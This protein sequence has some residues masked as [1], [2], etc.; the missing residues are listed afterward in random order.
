MGPKPH[1]SFIFLVF[2]AIIFGANAQFNDISDIASIYDIGKEIFEL[3][4]DSWIKVDSMH[5][6]EEITPNSFLRGKFFQSQNL[7]LSKMADISRRTESLENSV[8]TS[9]NDIGRLVMEIPAQLR[10]EL[11]LD[12]LATAIRQVM[13]AETSMATYSQAMAS[14]A[15]NGVELEVATLEDFATSTVSHASH[16]IRSML[17]D[18]HSMVVPKHNNLG[19]GGIFRL[20]L[21]TMKDGG[22]GL[23]SIHQSPQQLIFN[24]YNLVT[25]T[26]IKG[27]AMMQFSWMLLKLYNKGN[28]TL[29]AELMRERVEARM[30]EKIQAARTAMGRASQELWV[31]DPSHHEENE[32]FVQLTNV[33]QGHIENEV[34]LN[35][36]GTCRESCGYYQYAR[37]HD[38]YKDQFCK[39]QPKCNGRIFDCRFIDSDASVC[40]SKGGSTHRKYDWIEY[41][42]GRTLGRKGTCE[43]GSTKVDS[44]WRWLFW[45]C[46]YC[47]CLCDEVGLKSDRYFSLHPSLARGVEESFPNSNRAVTGLRFV[48]VN[49]VIH[50]QVQD[51]EI[52]PGG[53]IN[54]STVEWRPIKPFKVTDNNIRRDV[55][56]HIITWEQRAVDLDDLKAPEGSI[57]TGVQ[58]RRIGAHLNL[59]I[60]TTPF[61]F[62]TGKLAHRATSEWISNDNTPAAVTEPRKEIRMYSPD[63]PTKCPTRSSVVSNHDQYIRFTHSDIDRDV[64]QTTVPFIDAQPVVPDPHS[65]LTGAGLFYKGKRNCGGFISLKV[66]TYD[67]SKHL[68]MR[69]L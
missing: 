24:L 6:D 36:K 41:E 64:A 21:D 57:L 12:T 42:N 33:L 46:S 22:N 60:L 17:E 58:L 68:H 11:R 51:G 26:E 67:Y 25:L 54:S 27:Y 44:W 2:P 45:H 8:K 32:T 55:D 13:T 61:N 34:D 48:K 31:C 69:D 14:R 66:M 43:R 39:K 65:L 16:S 18:I 20:L 62:T 10:W 47:L 19:H 7:V 1:L 63:V 40:L 29:E 30:D 3:I 28:F 56:Y 4:S 9:L 59:E 38:C 52:L 15:G 49:R 37:V 53:L 5:R 23:C 50:L 35:P